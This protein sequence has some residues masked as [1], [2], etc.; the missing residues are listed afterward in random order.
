MVVSVVSNH[1]SIGEEASVAES[2]RV[3]A[4]ASALREG[5]EDATATKRFMLRN[6]ASNDLYCPSTGAKKNEVVRGFG[7]PLNDVENDI[8]T[9]R[10]IGVKGSFLRW[11]LVA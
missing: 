4:W 8:L 3:S 11:V 7:F 2:G 6:P 5:R 9:P 10:D 1:Y